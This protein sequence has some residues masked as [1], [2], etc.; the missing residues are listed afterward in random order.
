M[1]DDL[2]LWLTFEDDSLVANASDVSY[3]SGL[4]RPS[5]PAYVLDRSPHD[6]HATVMGVANF[7]VLEESNGA[8]MSGTA[9]LIAACQC[10]WLRVRAAAVCHDHP[11]AALI[12]FVQA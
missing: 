6:R 4:T 11:R 8:T 3:P 12:R 7:N 5:N 9:C 1:S 10:R 2:E